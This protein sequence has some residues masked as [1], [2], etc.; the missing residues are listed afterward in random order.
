[1]IWLAV[2]VGGGLGS[3]ARFGVGKVCLEFYS[4][5]FPIGTFISNI[6]SCVILAII[7]SLSGDSGFDNRLVRSAVLVGF[8][9]GFSTF[10]T[11][12]Y[13]TI[14][15]IKSGNHLV[16]AGNMIVSVGVCL[17]LLYKLTK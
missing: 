1:M 9:G 8:C 6:L 13:E 17:I 7:V 3:V 14:Q 11:F 2:F 5:S 16:A 10:S 15:L 12:S 4:G